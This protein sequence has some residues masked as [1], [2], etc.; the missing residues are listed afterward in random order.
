M[1]WKDLD[2]RLKKL[3][4]S[5]CGEHG[6][7]TSHEKRVESMLESDRLMEELTIILRDK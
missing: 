1:M 2:P 7:Q 3:Y 5:I 6:E 4:Q